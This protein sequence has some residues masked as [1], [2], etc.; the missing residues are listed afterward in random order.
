MDEVF[1]KKALGGRADGF[2]RKMSSLADQLSEVLR[3]LPKH[4]TEMASVP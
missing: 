2:M 1:L 3:H 4:Q